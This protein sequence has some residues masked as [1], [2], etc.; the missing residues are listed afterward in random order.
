MRLSNDK[1][2]KI[3]EQILAVLY[4]NAP[5]PLFTYTIAKEVVRDEEFTKKL[6]VDLRKK[7]LVVEVKKNA[8]GKPYSRRS[9][10]ILSQ[11]A[12]STYKKSQS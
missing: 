3:S 1:V 9:R 2:V 5:K 4:S 10:W 8:S 7:S 12:Y 6:L 11:E